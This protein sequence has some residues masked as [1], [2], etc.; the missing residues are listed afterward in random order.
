MIYQKKVMK[1]DVYRDESWCSHDFIMFF[2]HDLP[3]FIQEKR[4]LN[5]PFQWILASKN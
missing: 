5:P 1:L 4:N 2:Y 3:S